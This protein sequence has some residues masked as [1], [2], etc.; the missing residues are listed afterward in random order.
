MPL[1]SPTLTKDL[2]AIKS[3]VFS[4]RSL[5]DTP[6]AILQLLAGPNTP[7]SFA[8]NPLDQSTLNMMVEM[9]KSKLVLALV[10]AVS[11]VSA[12]IGELLRQ[13]GLKLQWNHAAADDTALWDEA[14]YGYV[15]AHLKP[16]HD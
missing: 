4:S 16:R 12:H 2:Q 15:A 8:Y 14:M 1:V 5:S 10:Y 3:V 11:Q 7:F 6:L 9:N 13:S